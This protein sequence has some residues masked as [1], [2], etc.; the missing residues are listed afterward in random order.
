MDFCDEHKELNASEFM[1]IEILPKD[2]IVTL[3]Y[4]LNK[5]VKI[6]QLK[7]L[8][9]KSWKFKHTNYNELRTQFLNQIIFTKSLLGSG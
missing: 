5:P 8:I 7:S 1:F 9:E 3:S 4:Q 2:S 6:P